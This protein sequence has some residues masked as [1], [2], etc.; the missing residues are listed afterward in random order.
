MKRRL[1]VILLL[2]ALTAGLL[3]PALASPAPVEPSYYRLNVKHAETG[4]TEPLD[5][6]VPGDGSGVYVNAGQFADFVGYY[7]DYIDGNHC[8]IYAG[9]QQILFPFDSSDVVMELMGSAIEYET[10][11]PAL[12][13]NGVPWVPFDFTAVL[14]NSPYMIVDNALA[15]YQPKMTVLTALAAVEAERVYLGFDWAGEM[16]Y[17]DSDIRSLSVTSGIVGWLN[18]LC[19]GESSS[20]AYLFTSFTG[21]WSLDTKYSQ[22]IA[23]LFVSPSSAELDE[24]AEAS[25][26][27]SDIYGLL[28]DIERSQLDGQINR[29]ASALNEAIAVRDRMKLDPMTYSSLRMQEDAIKKFSSDLD[30]LENLDKEMKRTS[31]GLD[32]ITI[33]ADVVN[34][35]Y[36]YNNKDETALRTLKRYCDG[37]GIKDKGW[38]DAMKEYVN[39]IGAGNSFKFVAGRII[40]EDVLPQITQGITGA[41]PL[42]PLTYVLE[43][44][45]IAADVFPPLKNSLDSAEDFQLANRSLSYQSDSEPILSKALSGCFGSNGI[46]EKKLLAASDSALAYLKFSYIARDSALASYVANPVASQ[47]SK[48]GFS[49][50]M[51]K[52]NARISEIMAPLSQALGSGSSLNNENGAF[53]FLPSENKKYLSDWDDAVLLE[54]LASGVGES[55]PASSATKDPQNEIYS[56]PNEKNSGVISEDEAIELARDT[57]ER[58]MFGL[59]ALVG[60]MYNYA[61]VDYTAVDGEQ[62]YVIRVMV[63]DIASSSSYFVVPASGKHVWLGV[64]LDSGYYTYTGID[65]ANAS[66]GDL[67]NGLSGIYNEALEEAFQ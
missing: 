1:T 45:N 62:A 5:F 39:E 41:L 66:M 33:F 10:P 32:A 23:A 12:C 20:W 19:S 61:C 58:Y 26:G 60:D 34:Y 21:T 43:G 44:W 47:A 31:M 64:P 54:Y 48:D 14:L 15:V 25:G 11:L 55:I 13:T 7:F 3:T 30:G 65:L 24:V 40:S 9:Y 35:G 18:G 4:A 6:M 49:E 36:Q 53:G 57:M 46:N 50:A 22:D 2:A 28:S 8:A 42:G 16:G 27:M 52:K 17:S 51:G 67:I 63:D 56:L 29:A 37:S 59:D 38:T